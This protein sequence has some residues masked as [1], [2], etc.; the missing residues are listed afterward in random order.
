MWGLSVRAESLRA[1]L[2][3]LL[4]ISRLDWS[5]AQAESLPNQGCHGI[6]RGS[7][8]QLVPMLRHRLLAADTLTIIG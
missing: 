7:V 8:A 4:E 2:A 1:A 6:L 3:G 5:P